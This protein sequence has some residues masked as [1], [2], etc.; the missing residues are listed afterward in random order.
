[1]GSV[2]LSKDKIKVLQR[3]YEAIG[4]ELGAI[5]GIY[6]PRTAAAEAAI[7]QALVGFAGPSTVP[8]AWLPDVPMDRVIFHWTAGVYEPNGLD[9]HSYHILID[10]EGDLVRGEFSIADNVRPRPGEYAAHT[11]NCNSG[12]IGVALC[13]MA[14][15]VERPFDPGLRPIKAVQWQKLAHVL[16]D[17]CLFYNIPITPRTVLSHAEVQGTL[18]IKQRAKWDIARLP[19]DDTKTDAT[20]IGNQMRGM[21]THLAQN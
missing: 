19:W 4:F 1:M 10:G 17:L 15:A 5:D 11:L 18:G 20:S 14:G 8:A 7:H 3:A 12:S 9:R 16:T 21:V 6:G 13:G 2:M